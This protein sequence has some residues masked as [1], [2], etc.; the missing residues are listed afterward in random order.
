MSPDEIE[1]AKAI[2]VEYDKDK[3][4]LY[5]VFEITEEK[6]KRSIKEDWTKNIELY[7]VKKRK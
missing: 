2:R 3:D 4:K 1:V 6:L 7:L 5:L